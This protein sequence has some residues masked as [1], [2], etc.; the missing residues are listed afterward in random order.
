M[1]GA[2][3]S[4]L[5]ALFKQAL[6]VMVGQ[7]AVMANGIVDSV[8]AGHA[9]AQTLAAVAVGN[10]V[11]ISLYV[12]LMGIILGLTPMA[13]RLYGAGEP[14]KIGLLAGQS[15]WIAVALAVLGCS[16]MLFPDPLLSLANADAALEIEIRQYLL[17]VA[18]GL[19][20]ALFF[21]VFHAVNQAIST[22][23]VVM[24]IQIA[25][26]ALKIPL[27]AWLIWGGLGVPAMGAAGCGWSTA[28]VMWFAC[29]SS[30]A[31]WL[32][33]Q[34]YAP[35]KI[36]GVL[37]W[38]RWDL[39]KPLFMMGLPIGG[40]YLIEVT[41]FTMVAV[42]VARFG[43]EIVAG[44]QIVSNLT[45]TAYMLPLSLANATTVLTAQQLGASNPERARLFVL[46]GL[47]AA[48]AC[49]LAVIACYALLSDLLISAYTSDAG[50]RAIA[51]QLLPWILMY[52]LID[53]TQ[54]LCAFALRAYGISTT[55]MLIYGVCLWGFG[56]GG[57]I[58]L[59]I[60]NSPPLMAEGFWMASVGSLLLAG[61]LLAGLLWREMRLR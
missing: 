21:R 54:T 12:G 55:P 39:L 44:H 52:H 58:I 20:A 18:I 7:L 35:L 47:K 46:T 26:L 38:P 60:W 2:E 61:I 1:L 13:S 50:T 45:A 59:G 32:T 33:E 41:A 3:L 31:L 56:L 49:A 51:F 5:R 42:L 11:Y 29:L 28:I 43:I 25:M 14:H 24:R 36:H 37:A 22:P 6:P 15:L 53:A 48:V 17:A 9:D 30:L 27:N 57:G 40:A 16:A 10:A 23:S 34:R 8:M 4:P 19:P